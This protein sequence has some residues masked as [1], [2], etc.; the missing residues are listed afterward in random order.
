MGTKQPST[1]R[2]GMGNPNGIRR[3]YR[4]NY[5]DRRSIFYDIDRNAA[6]NQQ[7][8]ERWQRGAGTFAK[9]RMGNA[10]NRR[11]KQ[12]FEKKRHIR[13]ASE[14]YIRSGSKRKIT[15][16]RLGRTADGLS[17]RLDFPGFPARPNET[18]HSYEPPRV[19][20]TKTQVKR[21]HRIK[22]LGNAVVPQQAFPFFQA[23]YKFLTVEN[24]SYR[25]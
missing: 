15:E 1:E 2:N 5:R 13:F 9:N 22:A 7:K 17:G 14:R 6:Q 25:E 16:S 24:D 19:S 23:V 12:R 21:T 10:N 20:P 8:R 3:D 18:Q 4:R 11:C